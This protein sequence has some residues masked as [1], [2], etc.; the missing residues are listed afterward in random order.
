MS[1]D[2]VK[3]KLESLKRKVMCCDLFMERCHYLVGPHSIYTSCV[4]VGCY[5]FA[6]NVVVG[7]V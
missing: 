6:C 3:S 4:V 7:G 5:G 2:G 1:S